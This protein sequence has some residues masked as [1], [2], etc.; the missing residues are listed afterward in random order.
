MV[1]CSKG[2]GNMTQLFS[3]NLDEHICFKCSSI[4]ANKEE[5]LIE[6]IKKECSAQTCFSYE[7]DSTPTAEERLKNILN[8]IKK[9]EQ[10]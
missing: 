2:C 1:P 5:I 7:Y 4:N 6:K 3:M 9:Y 8:L 10:Q